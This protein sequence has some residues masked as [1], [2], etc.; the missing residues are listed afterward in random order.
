MKVQSL[1]GFRDFYPEE[2]AARR[3]V[4]NKIF[5]TVRRYGFREVDTPSVE[6]MELFKVK[7]GEEIVQQTFSF[8]DKGDREITLIPELTP[9]VARMV[10][11]REKALKRPIKWFSMP[12]MWRYEEPQS[13]RLRE[14]YQLNVDIYGVPGPDADAEVLAAGIDLMLDLGLEGEFIFK[15]SDR[16]FMQGALEGLGVTNVPPV[17]AA[18]DKRGKI[19]PE[20]FKQL[21]ATAGLDDFQMG[22]LIAILDAKGPLAEALPKVK[23]LLAR[24]DTVIAGVS[25]L[26]K[27]AELMTMYN[28]V[29]YCE[30]DPAIIRG[31]AYYTGT[32]FEC[33]DVRGE[34][35]AVFGGGRY[36]KI[37]GLFGGEEMPAVGFGMGDAVLEILMRRAGVWPQEAIM[38]DYYILTTKPEYT[39]TRTFLAQALRQKGLIVEVDLQGRNFGNQ[40]KYAN[41]IGAKYV[42]ILGEK[43]MSEGK[44]TVKDMKSGEQVTQEVFELLKTVGR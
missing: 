9:T 36:D 40:M 42:L 28:M 30:F 8:K 17:F 38:T 23:A 11:D 12:K 15:I 4:L 31:L 1:K 27:L 16:R 37:V 14:F 6:S 32:V 22:K 20:E 19:S 25:N 7:S 21:L 41:S 33:F 24:N 5:S 35:R 44:V 13:G 26:E 34:L 29:Q 2:M 43:E 39:E 10:V 3:E 18:I